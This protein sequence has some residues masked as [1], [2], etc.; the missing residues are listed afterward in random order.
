MGSSTPSQTASAHDRKS[1]SLSSPH[2]AREFSGIRPFHQFGS[3]SESVQR[4]Y[5]GTTYRLVSW[6]SHHQAELQDEDQLWDRCMEANRDCFQTLQVASLSKPSWF[7]PK[8]DVV[9][10]VLKNPSIIPDDPPKGVLMRHTEALQVFGQRADFYFL[11]PTFVAETMEVYTGEMARTDAESE[12]GE[13]LTLADCYGGTLRNL[14][15]AKQF[16]AGTI[17]VARYG[18]QRGVRASLSA[19]RHVERSISNQV[20]RRRIKREAQAIPT[21]SDPDNLRALLLR[22]LE[23][24][25]WKEA[26]VFRD[27]LKSRARDGLGGGLSRTGITRELGLGRVATQARSEGEFIRLARENQTTDASTEQLR[28]VYR[29]IVELR[30]WDPVTCFEVFDR[31]GKLWLEAHWFDAVD[32]KRYVHY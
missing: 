14:T 1:H 21:G 19:L 6:L 27:G 11:R 28:A 24:G 12:K 10:E 29:E 15:L 26:D 4:A 13:L 8:G 16:A 18:L 17:D 20:E 30:Q 2:H 7:L 25:L 22:S 3:W 9:F 31:P 23:L 5:P 32:G